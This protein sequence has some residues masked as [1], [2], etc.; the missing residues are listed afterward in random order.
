MRVFIGYGYNPRD[1]WVETY[2]VPMVKAFGCTVEHGKTVYGG[3]LPDEVLR[4]IRGSDAMMGFTTQR[5]P[6]GTDAS[7]QPIFTT[8]PWVV[9]E[10]TAAISQNPP[11]PFV[12]VREER[13]IDPGGIIS[14]HN[15][16][17]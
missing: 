7:G 2:V 17:R 5:D 16:Q 12:E 15:A 11:I 13:V 1:K 3:A 9:Q 10:L 6:A 8:H 4:L 14:A